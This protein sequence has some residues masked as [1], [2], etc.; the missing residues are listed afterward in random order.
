MGE[1][2]YDMSGSRY[3]Y[4]TGSNRDR[5]D[6]TT[7]EIVDD[8]WLDMM[9]SVKK[10]KDFILCDY[11]LQCHYNLESIVM[12]A[13]EDIDPDHIMF[14]YDFRSAE[15]KSYQKGYYVGKDNIDYI[16]KQ[17]YCYQGDKDDQLPMI[18]EYWLIYNFHK[19]ILTVNGK[20]LD[21]EEGLENITEDHKKEIVDRI[22]LWIINVCA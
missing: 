8:Y 12:H 10:N 1:D 5:W 17:I 11:V 3:T 20:T 15:K 18:N 14:K 4:W 6:T 16:R 19:K 21:L 7:R 2:W 9:D 22:L 13:L